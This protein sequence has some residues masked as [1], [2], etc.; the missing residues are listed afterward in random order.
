MTWDDPTNTTSSSWVALPVSE[1]E[2]LRAERDELLEAVKAYLA[3][4]RDDGHPNLTRLQI[5]KD[6][7]TSIEGRA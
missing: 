5:L 7:L 1:H 4:T 3:H 6:A 2:R